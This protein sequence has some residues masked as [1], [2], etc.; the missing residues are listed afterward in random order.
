[1]LSEKTKLY[2]PLQFWY[3]YDVGLAIPLVSIPFRYVARFIR[4]Y[5]SPFR[6]DNTFMVDNPC[7]DDS[8]DIVTY[9]DVELPMISE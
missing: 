6:L 3:S 9:T 1:M 7:N 8:I 5:Y 2:V 4:G